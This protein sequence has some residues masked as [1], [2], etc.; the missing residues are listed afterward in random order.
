MA[1]R[2][3]IYRKYLALIIA[4]V[5]TTLV[6]SGAISIY[7]TYL[8]TR[9]SLIALAREKAAS[10]AGRIEQF[11]KEIEHQIGWTALPQIVEDADPKALRRNDYVKLLRQ[12]QAITEANFIHGNGC[13]QVVSSRPRDGSHR[14]CPKTARTA[15]RCAVQGSFRSGYFRKKPNRTWRSRCAP[16]AR[17]PA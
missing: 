11:V 2:R 1:A 5:A 7:F 8:E 13:L 15:L 10:A 17:A 6:V 14:D 9:D 4:L 12:V 16:G 3:R